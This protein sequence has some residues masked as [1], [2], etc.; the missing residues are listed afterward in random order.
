LE[1]TFDL[2]CVTTVFQ[3]TWHVG[4]PQHL[5]WPSTWTQGLIKIMWWG[6]LI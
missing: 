1:E 2:V 6:T 5:M 4:Q 3:S